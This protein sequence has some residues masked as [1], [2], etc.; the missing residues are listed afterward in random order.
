[1]YIVYTTSTPTFPVVHTT[2]D[3]T[4]DVVYANLVKYCVIIRASRH[5]IHLYG[6][7]YSILLLV[8]RSIVP[9]TT[10]LEAPRARGRRVESRHIESSRFVYDRRYDGWTRATPRRDDDHGP[11]AHG[12]DVDDDGGAKR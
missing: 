5:S 6:V 4:D 9:S 1:M 2:D 11:L 3:H 10:T 12:V 7:Q 8:V